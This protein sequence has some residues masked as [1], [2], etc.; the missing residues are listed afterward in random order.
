MKD[1]IPPFFNSNLELLTELYLNELED[2]DTQVETEHR[3]D[4][5]ILRK[6]MGTR[7]ARNS[8]IEESVRSLA[9]Q[10]EILISAIVQIHRQQQLLKDELGLFRNEY[11][12]YR[13][14]Q[15][16]R[17]AVDGKEDLQEDFENLKDKVED[18]DK[19]IYVQLKQIN[20][21]MEGFNKRFDDIEE[22]GTKRSKATKKKLS[23]MNSRW[24]KRFMYIMGAIILAEKF[25]PHAKEILGVLFKGLR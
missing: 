20:T 11:K 12:D 5:E 13:H 2:V 4:E 3:S 8:S 16:V 24:E 10:F 9:D 6:A 21:Q 14:L 15:D 18:P 7:K 17:E 25:S 23:T 22:L 19:G 1:K